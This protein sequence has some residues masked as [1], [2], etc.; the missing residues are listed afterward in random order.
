MH[1]EALRLEQ[2]LRLQ[3]RINPRS[4]A[5]GRVLEMPAAEFDDEVRRQLDDNPALGIADGADAHGSIDGD[6]GE[7]FAESAD[8]LQRADYADDDD[9]PDF[10]RRRYAEEPR[11]EAASYTADDDA[12]LFDTL[13]G[14]LAAENSLSGADTAIARHIVGNIDSNG[15]LTRSLAAI[16]DEIALTE[17]FDPAEADVRRIF[18][19]VRALEPAGI[20]ALDLRDC[21][22]LQLDRRAPDAATLTARAIIADH[23][24]L[25]AKMH[26]DRI[27]A[28]LE[29]DRGAMDRALAV[30]RTLN[31]RPASTLAT[32]RSGAAR[33]IVPDFIVDYDVNT[34]RFSVQPAASEPDLVVEKSF[35]IADSDTT[36][37]ALRKEMAFIRRR[38]DDA[39]SFIELARL[40]SQTLA[41]V[42]EAIVRI[43]HSFFASGD[44]ADIVPMILKD[45][46]Q[47]TDLDVSVVSRATAG[48]YV[49]APSGIYPLKM[50]FN[51]RPNEAT[52]ASTLRILEELRDILEHEDKKTPLSDRLLT[53][54]LAARGYDI[55]RRTVAK[56]RER[57]GF[58]VA[59]LR[60][61]F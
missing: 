61:L 28:A 27:M 18:D 43:Q 8:Q 48:K 53:D 50:F 25:F 34:G 30:I 9:A 21:L 51:E 19:A 32:G 14:R 38:R 36:P 55:A 16:A 47:A 11:A 15:Y 37:A 58:P 17:G 20:C 12:G 54:T 3:Q 24:P 40:R 57:L 4:V 10:G 35:D 56:Y 23:Y 26:F 22:L 41:V 42:I 49:L 52:D 46:A 6:D 45:V 31:P 60:K 5:L 44:P 2:Q 33:H 7:P 13:M 39:R 1:K 29:I 59:R